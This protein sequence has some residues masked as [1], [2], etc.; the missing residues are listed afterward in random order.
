MQSDDLSHRCNRSVPPRVGDLAARIFHRT[1]LFDSAWRER[2]VSSWSAEHFTE[3]F[4]T[5]TWWA[6]HE[7][8]IATDSCNLRYTVPRRFVFYVRARSSLQ[9][10]DRR[11]QVLVHDSRSG[12]G[13][14]HGLH[15]SARRFQRDSCIFNVPPGV[16]SGSFHGVL[17]RAKE[18]RSCHSTPPEV[19]RPY[20]P[21]RPLKLSAQFFSNGSSRDHCKSLLGA[22]DITGAGVVYFSRHDLQTTV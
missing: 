11:S 5:G 6:Q 19:S 2:F 3:A 15:A 14:S 18:G 9:R 8:P 20:S 1:E 13:N 12:L 4:W 10:G 16:F 17:P 21:L 22:D 7:L